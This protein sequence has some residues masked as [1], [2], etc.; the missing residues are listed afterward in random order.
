MRAGLADVVDP[1]APGWESTIEAA[2]DVAW[3]SHHRAGNGPAVYKADI[4]VKGENPIS[5]Y[6]AI[7]SP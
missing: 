1:N 3:K 5:G 7:L 6:K 2:V 4:Y